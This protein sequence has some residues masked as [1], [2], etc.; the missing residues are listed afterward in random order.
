MGLN[1]FVPAGDFFNF[2]GRI[3]IL[4]GLLILIGF[5]FQFKE[6]RELNSYFNQNCQIGKKAAEDLNYRAYDYIVSFAESGKFN[7]Q[8][9]I[10]SSKHKE[11]KKITELILSNQDCF[12]PTNIKN[13]VLKESGTGGYRFK[14][15]APVWCYENT[16]FES[17]IEDGYRVLA[18]LHPNDILDMVDLLLTDSFSDE[19]ETI[20][21]I[22]P[23]YSRP[24]CKN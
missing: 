2:L 15:S 3:S 20:E 22:L 5:G 9:N 10:S 8:I 13:E 1:I 11:L 7:E 21:R 24:I 16:T 6:S 4:I 18:K 23:R 17:Q 14:Y 12:T 19:Y